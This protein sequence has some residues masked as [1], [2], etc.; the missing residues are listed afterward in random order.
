MLL[1]SSAQG[2]QSS[3]C[4]LG[5]KLD[6]DVFTDIGSSQP[7][8][9][10]EIL[11]AE[12]IESFSCVRWS[13]FGDNLSSKQSAETFAPCNLTAASG[14]IQ[15]FTSCKLRKTVALLALFLKL[16]WSTPV[17]GEIPTHTQ[18]CFAAWHAPK[19]MT[20]FEMR[21]CPSGED[22]QPIHSIWQSRQI[23]L[24]NHKV[25]CEKT[26]WIVCGK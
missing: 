24:Q 11:T 18:V 12:S 8:D 23:K 6:A 16:W 19:C 25:G 10:S 2:N 26:S 22:N 17:S 14:L 21:K 5:L 3:S 1:S 4:H 13:P 9:S 15:H 7:G 20:C